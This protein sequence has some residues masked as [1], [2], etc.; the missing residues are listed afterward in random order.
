MFV[1]VSTIDQLASWFPGT[2]IRSERLFLPETRLWPGTLF[3]SPP[4]DI[5]YGLSSYRASIGGLFWSGP[6]DQ[7]NL[8]QGGLLNRT[9]SCAYDNNDR[10]TEQ[11]K[12]GG[13]FGDEVTVTTYNDHGDKESERTTTIINP[14]VGREYSLTETGTIIPA[15]KSQPAQPPSTYEVQYK[16][17]YDSYGSWTEQ[18]SVVRNRPDAPLEPGSIVHRTLTYY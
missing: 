4:I 10:V 12:R 1:D 2:T 18:A 6:S 11:H 14:E 8:L 9:I 5:L 13:A 3:L 7:T 16:Y 17:Q 15:G